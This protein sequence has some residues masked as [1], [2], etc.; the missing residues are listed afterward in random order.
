M[1]ERVDLLY[2]AHSNVKHCNGCLPGPHYTPLVRCGRPE[3]IRR[4][5]NEGYIQNLNHASLKILKTDP[6]LT[7]GTDACDVHHLGPRPEPRHWVQTCPGVN[8]PA[9]RYDFTHT[10]GS[11]LPRSN[12][13]IPCLLFLAI[14]K[15]GQAFRA[16]RRA[17]F[18]AVRS[19]HPGTW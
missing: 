15:G 19:F 5:H 10:R 11:A 7:C 16:T 13:M 6:L 3:W 2:K 4:R 8:A 9:L 12:A 17:V 1:M 18:N 14:C